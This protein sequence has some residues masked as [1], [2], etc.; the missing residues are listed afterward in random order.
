MEAEFRKKV[1]SL[2]K[3]AMEGMRPRFVGETVPGDPFL[4]ERDVLYRWEVEGSPAFF[5]L[6]WINPKA[7]NSFTVECGWSERG[8]WPN[9]ALILSPCSRPDLGLERSEEVDGEFQFRIGQVFAPQGDHWWE[10]ADDEE[11]YGPSGLGAMGPG[12]E[13]PADFLEKLMASPVS[14][15]GQIEGAVAD[16]LGKIREFVIPLFEERRGRAA[17]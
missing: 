5:V 17:G 1:K 15:R 11:R 3:T 6:L 16:A 7:S 14:K 9:L 12:G 10:V 13:V 2:F 8:R 4:K